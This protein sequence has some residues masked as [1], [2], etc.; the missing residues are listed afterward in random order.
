MNIIPRKMTIKF[1][2]K[3]SQ[4]NATIDAKRIKTNQIKYFKKKRKK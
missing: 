3:E 1:S 4:N 2:A